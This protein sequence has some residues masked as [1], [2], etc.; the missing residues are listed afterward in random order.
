MPSADKVSDG[1][2]HRLHLISRL[3]RD[4]LDQPTSMKEGSLA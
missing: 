4:E 3:P 2:D 1:Q